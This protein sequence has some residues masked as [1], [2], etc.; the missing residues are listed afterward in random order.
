MMRSAQLER[1]TCA[2]C[3]TEFDVDPV[4]GAYAYQCP[5]CP[6]QLSLGALRHPSFDPKAL[7]I[8]HSLSM[9]ACQNLY[10]HSLAYVFVKGDRPSAGSGT[11]VKLGDRVL[12]STTRHTIPRRKDLVTCV[13][14]LPPEKVERVPKV[15]NLAKSDNHDVG[16]IEL[17]ADAPRLLGMDVI[18]VDRIADLESGRHYCK[19]WMIGYPK[20]N[21]RANC[22]QQGVLGFKGN[23]M[24][25]E[26]IDPIAWGGIRMGKDDEPLCA[27]D[28]VMT[29]YSLDGKLFV[30]SENPNRD[31]HPPEPFGISGGG[32]WQ[33]RTPAEDRVWSPDELCLFA[34]QAAWCAGHEHL[35]A[36]QVIHWLRLVAETYPELR[37]EL[38]EQFPRLNDLP[39]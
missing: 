26:P 3:G 29:Y 38:C 13:A 31:E 28:H 25:C 15:L 17:E 21:Q 8:G 7:D 16:L 37:E 27:D 33:C 20:A 1:G 2:W 23:S 22:P 11:L 34:I 18:E 4:Q 36:I 14:K 10:R 32:L 6:E 39:A 30:H 24:T 35:K 12:I 9:A 19:A 5:G